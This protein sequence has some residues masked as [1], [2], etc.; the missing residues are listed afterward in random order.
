MVG[1]MFKRA[2]WFAAGAAAGLGGAV[3]T[4]RAVKRTASKLAPSHVAVSAAGA[5]RERGRDL[6]E[7]VR[8]GRAAMVAKERELKAQ[9]DADDVASA[10]GGQVVE[11]QL[12][13]RPVRLV[14]LPGDVE[15]ARRPDPG[16]ERLAP[17]RQGSR[18]RS[19]R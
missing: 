5:V 12:A 18:R 4:Q 16:P 15:P 14:V 10:Q 8:E 19:R 11:G 17:A 9:R 6:A 3:W 2:T 13:G 7:A 1:T